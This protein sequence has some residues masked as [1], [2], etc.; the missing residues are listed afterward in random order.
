[1][2]D[3]CRSEM[4][5]AAEAG[6]VPGP[7]RAKP[8]CPTPVPHGRY[9]CEKRCNKRCNKAC[10]YRCTLGAGL[11][12]NSKPTRLNPPV[13]E[14]TSLGCCPFCTWVWMADGRPSLG[15]RSAAL[16]LLMVAAAG[17]AAACCPDVVASP[18]GAKHLNHV[19]FAALLGVPYPVGHRL[20]RTR[21][22][23]VDASARAGTGGL[24]ATLSGNKALR[25]VA[26][27][28]CLQ[29]HAGGWTAVPSVR[30][31]RT[32]LPST[33]SPTDGPGHVQIDVLVVRDDQDDSFAARP[34]TMRPRQEPRRSDRHRPR[35]ST[36]AGRADS[37]ALPAAAH[38]RAGGLTTASPAVAG[39]AITR[40]IVVV[41][42]TL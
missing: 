33:A 21:E 1:M 31:P 8:S 7:P 11:R 20:R 16:R 32:G 22:V 13:S 19:E 37:S 18:E 26:Q 36:G 12:L 10:K 24:G 39:S 2:R 5:S 40:S 6:Q 35:V 15:H 23:D 4:R 9:R 38:R 27:V 42:N 41:G 30:E 29:A 25:A 34:R 14:P 17:W 3:A 28:G